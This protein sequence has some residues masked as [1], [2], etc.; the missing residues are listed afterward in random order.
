[1]PPVPTLGSRVS[2]QQ[3]I[4]YLTQEIDTKVRERTERRRESL[5]QFL[6]LAINE[7]LRTMGINPVLT[8][9]SQHTFVRRRQPAQPRIRTSLN[10]QGRKSI[11]GWY[12]RNE[13]QHLL[14]LTA[15]LGLSVQ[16]VGEAGIVSLMTPKR[17]SGNSD[18]NNM[19]SSSDR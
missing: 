12:Q 17:R 2:K 18:H 19:D 3:V 5:Q 13:V 6:A 7:Q 14:D 16:D 4:V 1:M 10:R 11:A 8:V 9:S 15:E